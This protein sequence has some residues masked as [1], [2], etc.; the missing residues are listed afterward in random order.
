MCISQL[1]TW[2]LRKPATEATGTSTVRDL[3]N[4]I[5]P[6]S[7]TVSQSLVT[8]LLCY[9]GLSILTNTFA[10]FTQSGLYEADYAWLGI[11][12]FYF[13]YNTTPMQVASV[14][15]QLSLFVSL[16]SMR[17]GHLGTNPLQLN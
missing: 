17:R 14:V 15:A 13:D 10:G 8:V 3:S 16:S 7:P 5:T 9:T 4:L 2:T 11:I 6:F 12:H 1:L